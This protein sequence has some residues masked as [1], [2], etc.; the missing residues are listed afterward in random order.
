MRLPSV[1]TLVSGAGAALRRF[2]FAIASGAIAAAGAVWL[3]EAS[4]AHRADLTAPSNLLLVGILGISLLT[5]TQVFAEHRAWGQ[6]RRVALAL[7]GVAALTAY[8]LVLPENVFQTYHHHLVTYGLLIIASH[9]AVAVAPYTGPANLQR[10]WDFNKSLFLRFLSAIL[11]SGV[12][13]AGL[14]IAMVALDELL[15]VEIK[16]RMYG[17]LFAIIGLGFNTWYF[18]STVPPAVSAE[19]Q[20]YPRALKTFSQ[21]ILIPLVAIYVLILYAYTAKILVTWAWPEGWV[22]N[23]VLGFS[24]AGILALLFIYPIREREE[25][26][27]IRTI[28]RWYF[29]ALFPLTILLLLAIW[30]RVTEYGITPNRYFVL[31]MGLWLTGLVVYFTLRKGGNIAVIPLTFLALTLVS[32]FGPWGALAVSE[33]SQRGRLEQ[34]LVRHDILQNGSIVRAQGDVV[35]EDAAEISSIVRYLTSMHGPESLRPWFG[36][37]LDTLA[38]DTATG[39]PN[40]RHEKLAQR[41]VE[42]MGVPFAPRWGAKYASLFFRTADGRLTAITGYDHLYAPGTLTRGLPAARDSSGM[43]RA[44]LDPDLG[45]LSL[46]RMEGALASDSAVVSLRS[47]LKA[48]LRSHPSAPHSMPAEMMV[49]DGSG[50]TMD[51]RVLLVQLQGSRAGDSTTVNSVIPEFLVRIKQAQASAKP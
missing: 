9:F 14:S 41:L 43:F 21:Y 27:W 40:T 24:V 42:A 16:E 49:L 18:L 20:P 1:T 6:A 7:T 32:A 5:W 35:S 10:F 39:D 23:L 11:Y 26:R 31:V 33:R 51:V 46:E 48:A 30:R 44:R 25:N 15:G 47:W 38:A 45:T 4:D 8:A 37:R 12:L 3:I 34:L 50:A 36:A 13:F 29:P 17:Q 19:E 2:P 22:A 28:W